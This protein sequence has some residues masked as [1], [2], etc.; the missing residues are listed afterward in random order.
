MYE[1][2]HSDANAGAREGAMFLPTL[3]TR[4]SNFFAR[5]PQDARIVHV[6]FAAQIGRKKF[7]ST[8]HNF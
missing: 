3:S 4:R 6:F 5:Y 7:L 8:R 1:K 2:N